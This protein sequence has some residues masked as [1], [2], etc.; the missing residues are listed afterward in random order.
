MSMLIFTDIAPYSLGSCDGSNKV[1]GSGKF[2]LLMG[3]LCALFLSSS[4]ILG[5]KL[6]SS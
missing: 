4:T 5:L 3:Y 2:E 6:Y 1:T